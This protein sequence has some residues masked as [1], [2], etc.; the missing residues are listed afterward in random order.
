MRCLLLKCWM[1]QLN[2]IAESLFECM[3]ADVNKSLV[4]PIQMSPTTSGVLFCIDL[5]LLKLNMVGQRL[6]AKRQ[7]KPSH[8]SQV[9]GPLYSEERR[10]QLVGSSLYRR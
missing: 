4:G 6:W 1:L 7:E 5:W 9:K 3:F 2:V 8:C 10:W